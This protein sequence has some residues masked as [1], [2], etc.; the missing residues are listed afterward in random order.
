MSPI[1]TI[2]PNLLFPIDQIC[3]FGPGGQLAEDVADARR[4]DPP[5]RGLVARDQVLALAVADQDVFRQ[6]LRVGV[7]LLQL[8]DQGLAG[9]VEDIFRQGKGVQMPGLH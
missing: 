9:G 2:V 7:A 3:Y 1:C 6:G 8:L 5:G 4:G